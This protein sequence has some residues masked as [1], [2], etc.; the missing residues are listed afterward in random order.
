MPAAAGCEGVNRWKYGLSDSPPYVGAPNDTRKSFAA[1]D[2]T[3]LLGGNDIKPD[4]VLDQSC[5]AQAQGRNRL[6][7][8]RYFLEALISMNP[9]PLL[10]HAIVPGVGHNEREM[11]FSKQGHDAIFSTLR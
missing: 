1:R 4:G 2:I 11:L 3:L 9:A 7:R 10:R 8:G 6:E 5:A